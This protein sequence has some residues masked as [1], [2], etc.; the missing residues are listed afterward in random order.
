VEYLLFVAYL[1]LFAWLVTKVKFFTRAELTKSQLIILLL[2]KIIACIFYGWIGTY[3]GGLAKM[4]DTWRYHV[5]SVYEYRLLFSDPGEYLTNLFY[6]PYEN[7]YAKFFGTSDSYWNDLK[8][9]F[10]VKT[11][12]VF[13]MLSFGNYYING[14]FYAFITLFGPV[15]VYRVMTDAFPGKR[16]PILLATFLIPSFLYW[17]SGIHKEGFIFTGIG[18][19]M[20]SIYFGLKDNRW[21]AKR[22][23]VLFAGLLLI[24]VLRNFIIITIVPAL[25][26]WIIA[27]RFKYRTAKVFAFLYLLFAVLFFTTKYISPGLDFPR[28]VTDRQLAFINIK[29]PGTLPVNRVE[30]NAISFFENIPQA[31]TLTILR[32]YPTDVK[33]FLSLASALEMLAIFGMLILLIFYRGNRTSNKPFIYFCYFFSFSL[34]LAIGFSQNNLGAISRY[35]S[36]ILPLIVVPIVAQIDWLRIQ[37]SLLTL[38]KK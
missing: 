13:N 38:I 31:V 15:A 36:V 27:A 34:L 22:L 37:K 18:L 1:V 9:N 2:L 3:Y 21:G 25:F 19:C 35:R 26:T 4:N 8:G 33:H 16:T 6:T 14:I 29:G 7:G 30:P 23:L 10:F 28:V 5:S 11:L 32:P 24:M 20:Y 17:C 12:S